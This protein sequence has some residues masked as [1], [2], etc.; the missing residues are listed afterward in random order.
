VV[1]DRLR[2]GDAE[3]EAAAHDLGEHFAMGRITADEH[4]E[5][6]DRIYAA[7]TRAELAPVFD[8]L[9]QPGRLERTRPAR[10]QTQDRAR[11]SA[12]G[13]TPPHLPFVLKALVGILVVVFVIAHLPLLIVALL[14]YLLVVRR[15]AH[16]GPWARHPRWR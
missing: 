8:D 11:G 7:R 16:R 14:V 9:P 1:S 12:R 3:R 15:V 13:W 6:L 10:R 2:I 4:G 5:R